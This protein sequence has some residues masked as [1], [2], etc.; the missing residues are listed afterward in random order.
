MKTIE[1]VIVSA[2]T[3][4]LKHIVRECDSILLRRFRCHYDIG[5]YVESPCGNGIITE[6]DKETGNC[7]IK[8]DKGI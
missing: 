1:N 5:D 7:T 8:L 3:F 2:T 6:L 4:Q